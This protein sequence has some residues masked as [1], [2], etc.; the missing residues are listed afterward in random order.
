MC[1]TVCHH[2]STALYS[3]QLKYNYGLPTTQTLALK[4]SHSILPSTFS[5]CLTYTYL[6]YTAL[7]LSACRVVSIL[8]ML[9]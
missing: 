9:T 3:C 4:H 5:L 1:T 2:I 6:F 8:H 7:K